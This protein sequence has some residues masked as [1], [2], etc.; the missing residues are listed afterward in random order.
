MQEGT[1][2]IDAKVLT[3]CCRNVRVKVIEYWKADIAVEQEVENIVVQIGPD[4]GVVSDNE[5]NVVEGE[6]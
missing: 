5:A 4:S 6:A 2:R 3:D 1:G